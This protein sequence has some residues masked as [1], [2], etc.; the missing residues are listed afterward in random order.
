MKHGWI[1]FLVAALLLTGAIVDD[2]RERSTH[3]EKVIAAEIG[4]NLTRELA[5]LKEEVA[6]VKMPSFKRWSSLDHAIFLID[7]GEVKSWSSNNIVIDAA[8]LRGDLSVKLF[9][10]SKRDLIVYHEFLDST[11][12]LI[13]II[14]LRQ[15]YDIVNQYLPADWNENIFP[16]QDVKILDPASSEGTPVC[17]NHE[18]C[19]FRIQLPNN[20]FV[21]TITPLFLTLGAILF[22]CWGIFNVLRHLHQKQKYLLAF[23][24]LFASLAGVRIAMVEFGFPGRWIYSEFFDSRYFASSSF[25]AS[26]GDFF[27][28]ALIVAIA[29]CYLFS[30]YARVAWLRRPL[31]K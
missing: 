12:A 25:N 22:A 10:T 23:V 2:V 11:R 9:Q 5:H 6:K 15:E 20:P 3:S 1:P 31:R 27:L 17:D 29:S 21:A 14:P 26:M 30:S 24:V 16:L 4:K 19:Y 28:N 13:G 18:Q 7:S 8:M